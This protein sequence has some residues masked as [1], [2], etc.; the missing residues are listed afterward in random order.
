VGA[1]V[2]SRLPFSFPAVWDR[3]CGT[4]GKGR[5]ALSEWQKVSYKLK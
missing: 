2:F 3:I 1:A 4:T 5:Q